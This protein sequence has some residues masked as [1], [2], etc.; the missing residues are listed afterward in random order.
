M[1]DFRIFQGTITMGSLIVTLEIGVDNRTVPVVLLES[2]ATITASQWST[3]LAID[4]TM[5]FQ[6]ILPF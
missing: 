1:D 2:S 5:Q 6:V 4:A 3:L